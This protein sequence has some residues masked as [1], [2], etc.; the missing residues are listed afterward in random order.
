M[1]QTFKK[2]VKYETDSDLVGTVLL[3]RALATASFNPE[4]AGAVVLPQFIA[5]PPSR[6]VG[7]KPRH[8][9]CYKVLR[10]GTATAGEQRGYQNF[11]IL[12]LDAL[13][14]ISIGSVLSID[15][16]DWT[17]KKRVNE[18]LG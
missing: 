16:V 6:K 5:N 4:P 2:L 13:S 3:G 7:L 9:K 18:E 17:V 11:V 8:V 1:T 15:G 14:A 10:A 12:T